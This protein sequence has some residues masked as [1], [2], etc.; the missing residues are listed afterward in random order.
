MTAPVSDIENP[1]KPMKDAEKPLAPKWIFKVIN[2]IM[3]ALLRSPLHDLLSKQLMLI[4]YSGSKTGKTYTH[5]IGYFEWSKD[6]LMAFSTA[7]WWTNVR[8]GKPVT[9]RLRGQWVE[10]IPKPITE[11]EAVINNIE[12]FIKRLGA[13]KAQM[14]PIGLPRDREPTRADLQNIP[15]TSYMVHFKIISGSIPQ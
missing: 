6:E 4:S 5:P 8:D 3:T 9:L 12:E 15:T 10:A 1:P 13:K 7:R 11:R 2:P 14:L